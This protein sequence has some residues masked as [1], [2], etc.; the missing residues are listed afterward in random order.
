MYDP[1]DNELAD[2]IEDA[3]EAYIEAVEDAQSGGD[4]D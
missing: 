2:N 4:N 1:N 3:A